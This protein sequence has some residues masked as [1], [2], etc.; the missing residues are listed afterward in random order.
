VVGS[1]AADRGYANRVRRA[2]RSWDLDDRV[3]LVGVV[4]DEGLEREYAEAEIFLFPTAYEGYGM[5]LGEAI[6]RELPFVAFASGGV[7]EVSGGRGCLVPSGDWDAFAKA[8]GRLIENGELRE[9]ASG[10]SRRLSTGL[11]RWEQTGACMHA[12]VQEVT[13]CQG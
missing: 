9:A 2:I 12:A 4:D 7:P 6:V 13:A 3:D 8:L 10:E 1:L 11:P 5:A